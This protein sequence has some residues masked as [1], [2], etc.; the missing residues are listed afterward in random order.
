MKTFFY[1]LPLSEHIFRGNVPNMNVL[2]AKFMGWAEQFGINSDESIAVWF[3]GRFD[4][5]IPLEGFGSGMKNNINKFAQSAREKLPKEANM[6]DLTD[7]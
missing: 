5:H 3:D 6:I 4:D 1:A 2:L 7:Y